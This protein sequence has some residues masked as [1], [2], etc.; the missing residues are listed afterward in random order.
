[1]EA[2]GT[3]EAIWLGVRLDEMGSARVRDSVGGARMG[4]FGKRNRAKQGVS[5]LFR[6]TRTPSSTS[7]E[8]PC[9]CARCVTTCLSLKHGS[10]LAAGS[11][12]CGHV[13]VLEFQPGRHR[14]EDSALLSTG[15]G[16]QCSGCSLCLSLAIPASNYG[17]CLSTSR[18]GQDMDPGR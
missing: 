1:M 10:G 13:W 2:D 14:R 16:V 5:K 8:Y 6:R 18:H 9:M 4:A 12:L 17:V 15:Y 3:H 11:G 7:T